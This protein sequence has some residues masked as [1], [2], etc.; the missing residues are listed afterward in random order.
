MADN[1]RIRKIANEINLIIAKKERDLLGDPN[2]DF[3][4]IVRPYTTTKVTKRVKR[5]RDMI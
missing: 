2:D 5:K 4:D 3:S 1:H